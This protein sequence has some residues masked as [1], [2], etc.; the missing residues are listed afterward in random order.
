MS[1][2]VKF[3]GHQRGW[4]EYAPHI[5]RALVSEKEAKFLDEWSITFDAVKD[6]PVK[7]EPGMRAITAT[8]D[9]WELISQE[10]ETHAKSGNKSP[11]EMSNSQHQA[12]AWCEAIRVRVLGKDIRYFGLS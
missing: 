6:Q 3:V 10:L 9:S 5:V 7:G 1:D 12:R 2:F 4:H 8:R 11:D